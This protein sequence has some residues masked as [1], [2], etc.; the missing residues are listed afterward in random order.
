MEIKE[1]HKKVCGSIATCEEKGKK[2]ILKNAT[3]F[4][5]VQI[6]GEVIPEGPPLKDVIIIFIKEK[7]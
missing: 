2:F 1:E 7:K 5:K 6:D 4:Y 3:D